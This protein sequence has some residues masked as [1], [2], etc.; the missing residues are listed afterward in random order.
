MMP[1][2]QLLPS[3]ISKVTVLSQNPQIPSQRRFRVEMRDKES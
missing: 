2:Q 3:S 1:G